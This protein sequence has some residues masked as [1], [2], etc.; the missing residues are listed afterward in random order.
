M[1]V[2]HHTHPIAKFPR[3]IHQPLSRNQI[4]FT[5]NETAPPPYSILLPN[6][7]KDKPANL[8]HCR[9]YGMPTMVMHHNAPDNTQAMPLIKPPKMNQQ[10]LPNNLIRHSL[11]SFENHPVFLSFLMA[12]LPVLLWCRFYNKHDVYVPTFLCFSDTLL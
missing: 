3:A 8:K 12:D 4:T 5:I 9:P 10:I 6:G 11:P 7:Q 1:M 2:M